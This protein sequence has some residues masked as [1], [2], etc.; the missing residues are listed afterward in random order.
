MV[1][2]RGPP[3]VQDAG[4]ANFGA[5]M[6]GVGGNREHGVRGGLEEEIVDYGLV[7]IGDGSDL[8]RQR[9]DDVKVG[10]LKEFG[11]AVLHPGKCLTALTLRAVTVAAAAV[12]DDG[13]ATFGVLA[14]CDIAAKR[15]RAAGLD[16]AHHLQLCV[17][18]VAAIG[19]TPSGAEVAEDV[20][21]FQSGTL[22]DGAETTSAGSP[23]VVV[24]LAYQAGSRPRAAPW[25]QRGRSARWCPT[26]NG[27]VTPGL[28]GYRCP[29]HTDA[30]QMNGAVR[31][32]RRA[33]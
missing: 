26:S 29:A 19:I 20:R 17:A 14:A 1:G 27:R 4:D 13:M 31:G 2:H 28:Y 8:G 25:S 33:Y 11:L 23:W 32:A 12:C 18:H 16:R 6:F 21:D 5:Q 9:E 22:H 30:S 3:G 24:A 7:L 15:R 10:D